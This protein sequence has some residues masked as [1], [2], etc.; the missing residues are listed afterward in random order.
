MVTMGV[1]EITA[2]I[3]ALSGFAVAVGGCC[4]KMHVRKF[5][6]LCCNFTTN[7]SQDGERSTP[8]VSILTRSGMREKNKSG[9]NV[10]SSEAKQGGPPGRQITV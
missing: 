9:N 7:G 6:S 2:L 5:S 3:L 8:F 1:T 10:T 4:Y